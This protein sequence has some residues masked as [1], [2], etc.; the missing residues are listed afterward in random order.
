[1]HTML[2]LWRILGDTCSDRKWTW[3]WSFRSICETRLGSLSLLQ[4]S[5]ICKIS[6]EIKNYIDRD[7]CYPMATLSY[8]PIFGVQDKVE[9]KRN[10][11]GKNSASAVKLT[12]KS[13]F[14]PFAFYVTRCTNIAPCAKI[15]NLPS[16]AARDFGTKICLRKGAQFLKRGSICSQK[17]DKPLLNLK[18]PLGIFEWL[19]SARFVP[20]RSS[21]DRG[22][23]TIRLNRGMTPNL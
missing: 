15:N 1:M 12:W 4:M 5:S 21:V 19:R 2:G 9:W 6:C 23:S 14:Q 18:C 13:N 3:I 10:A 8:Y 7:V 20:T 16:H 11:H 22:E 17:L